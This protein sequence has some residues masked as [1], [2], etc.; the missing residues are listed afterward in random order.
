M[1]ISAS[2]I[3]AESQAVVC[4]ESKNDKQAI[5]EYVEA[6]RT[7]YVFFPFLKSGFIHTARRRSSTCLSR[8]CPLPVTTVFTADSTAGGTEMIIDVILFIPV[9]RHNT[10]PVA[11]TA[12]PIISIL[13]RPSGTFRRTY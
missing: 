7:I 8:T 3:C 6:T 5:K 1:S 12:L 13:I 4:S 11:T 10:T 2:K 9:M